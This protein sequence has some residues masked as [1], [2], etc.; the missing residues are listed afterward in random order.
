MKPNIVL[1]AKALTVITFFVSLSVLFYFL[2]PE[3]ILR[4]VGFEN[5]YFI[6]FTL[7]FLGGLSTFSGIPYHIILMAFASGGLNPWLLGLLATAGVMLGDTTSFY[8]SSQSKK[9]LSERMLSVLETLKRVE[10]KSPRFMTAVF[11]L[12]GALIPFSNDVIVIPSGLLG[13]RFWRV[14]VPLGIGTLIF[15][16]SLALIATYLTQYVSVF[17]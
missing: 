16:M 1:Y 6:I 9:L 17:I 11:F 15:N 4:F 2:T 8:L 5:A 14:M 13:Y 7:A 10:N 12:Y 3:T